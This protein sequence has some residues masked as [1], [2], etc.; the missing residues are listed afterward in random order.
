MC[1]NEGFHTM[2]MSASRLLL[3]VVLVSSATA[4]VSYYPTDLALQDSNLK[5]RLKAQQDGGKAD[6]G[7]AVAY[8][9]AYVIP[10]GSPVDPCVT[11]R[12]RRTTHNCRRITG[13]RCPGRSSPTCTTKRCSTPQSPTGSKKCFSSSTLYPSSAAASLYSAAGDTAKSSPPSSIT[14]VKPNRN[15]GP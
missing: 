1:F 11:C 12:P 6:D 7:L 9:P 10:D 13:D 5:D 3:T 14:H 8:L 4:V 15:D 2:M